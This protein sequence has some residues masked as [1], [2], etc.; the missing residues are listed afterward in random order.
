MRCVVQRVRNSKIKVNEEIIALMEKGLLVYLGISKNDT[1]RDIEYLADKVSNL[2]IYPD[3]NGKMNLSINEI[4]G[5]ILVISQFTLYGDLRKGRRPSYD[6][7]APP[8][9][10][11]EFYL[12]FVETLRSK[13][14]KV[15]TGQFRAHM[16]VESLNDGPVTV[17]I[18]SEKI[19]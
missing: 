19:I 8:Q 3:Q 15:F 10:A 17:L 12:S 11:E 13:G 14:L 18:D 7:A 5:E 6:M 2:R 16:E 9:K 4:G 1:E